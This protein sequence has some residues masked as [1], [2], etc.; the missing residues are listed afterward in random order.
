MEDKKKIV[1]FLKE[2]IE[3]LENNKNTP[4]KE[5]KKSIKK[6]VDRKVR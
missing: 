6:L 2:A 3:I 4:E 1:D 5:V